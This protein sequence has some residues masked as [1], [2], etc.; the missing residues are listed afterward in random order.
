MA[1]PVEVPTTISQ[2]GVLIVVG[3]IFSLGVVIRHILDRDYSTSKLEVF[4]VAV[5]GFLAFGFLLC[6]P[7]QCALQASNENYLRVAPATVPVFFA[8]FFTRS[9]LV[10]WQ[11]S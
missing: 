2:L 1:P 3:V 5:G 9:E 10:R 7:F 11:Q 6:E 4:A 8:G